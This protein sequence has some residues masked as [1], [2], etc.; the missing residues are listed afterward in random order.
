MKEITDKRAG[1]KARTEAAAQ[2][3]A[4]AHADTRQ[5]LLDAAGEVFAAKGYEKATIRDIVKRAKAN[6]NAVNYYFRDKRNLYLSLFDFA[7][8][9]AGSRDTEAFERMRAMPPDERLRAFVRHMLATFEFKKKSPWQWRL[10]MREMLEP[11]GVLDVVVDRVIRP[12]FEFL[13]T[14][15][16]DIVGDDLSERRVRLCAEHIVAQC[17]HL[18]HGRTIIQKIIPEVD[19]SPE[20]MHAMADHVSAFS[21]AALKNLPREEST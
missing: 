17:V 10:M 7:R 3:E 18:V 16:T 19:Y 6:L 11:T 9:I 4:E 12:R 14:I 20:G 15:V 5:R 13:V 21:L 2:T 1:P 8:Q